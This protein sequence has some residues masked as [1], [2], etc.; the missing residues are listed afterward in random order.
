MESYGTGG[1]EMHC[2][3]RKLQWFRPAVLPSEPKYINGK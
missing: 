3:S 2:T 1:P